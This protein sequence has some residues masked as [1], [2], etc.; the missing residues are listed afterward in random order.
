MSPEQY[1]S[2]RKLQYQSETVQSLSNIQLFWISWTVTCQSPLS[3]E[4]SRQEYWCG[5]PCLSPGDLPDPGIT[6][7]SPTLQ[8][9][10]LPYKPQGKPVANISFP[11][12]R[13]SLENLNFITGNNY[14]QLF[15]MM[16]QAYFS[17][18]SKYVH[19]TL[20]SE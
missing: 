5:Q 11:K 6:P 7:G 15:F 9:D 10:S 19:E 8:A 2:I 17:S 13:C 1:L 16:F 4:F 14:C 12:F 3:V 20:N 18:C